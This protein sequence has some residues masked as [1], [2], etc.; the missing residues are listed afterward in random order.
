MPNLINRTRS[1]LL[2]DKYFNDLCYAMFDE[3]IAYGP[4]VKGNNDWFGGLDITGEN[5]IFFTARDDPWQYAGM[6]EIQ[7]PESTQMN[8]TAYHVNCPDCSHCVDL[9]G[10][11]D[12]SPAQLKEAKELAWKTITGWLNPASQKP[13]EEDISILQN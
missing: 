7:H 1:A 6:K 3:K 12:D 9:H 2:T 13:Q 5:I 4:N 8:M 10:V 11:T